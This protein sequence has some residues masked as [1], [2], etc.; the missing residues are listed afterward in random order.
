VQPDW[1]PAQRRQFAGSYAEALILANQARKLGL[2]SG[3][4]FEN[5]MKMQTEFVLQYLLAQALQERA[6]NVPEEEIAKYY[7]EHSQSFDEIEVQRV[8]VPIAQLFS[9]TGLP[10]TEIWTRDRAGMDAMKKAADELHARAR[11][12][13]DFATLQEDAY[14]AANYS[15]NQ[16]KPSEVAQKLRRAGIPTSQQSL[17]DLKPGDV[18]PIFAESNGYF[19]YKVMARRTL[20][21]DNVRAEIQK[22][23]SVERLRRFQTEARE[24]AKATLDESYFRVSSAPS[25]GNDAP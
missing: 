13:E 25:P 11:K 2:D 19:F 20:S 12:G 15:S 7:K 3:P 10:S 21:M 9:K 16:D 24:S 18:S 23:L 6:E 14:K 17:M 22:K 4:R 5:L 8:Y 1:S